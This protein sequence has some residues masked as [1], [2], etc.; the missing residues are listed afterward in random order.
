MTRRPWIDKQ[1]T[2]DGDEGVFHIS[3]DEHLSLF[4]TRV[5]V[6]KVHRLIESDN[7]DLTTR[8]KSKAR[9]ARLVG[10]LHFSA[11]QCLLNGSNT[12]LQGSTAHGTKAHVNQ[13]HMRQWSWSADS[14]LALP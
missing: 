12:S 5:K 9:H 14:R 10:S 4:Q 6:V 1:T 13:K 11:I 7:A 3:H 2:T 8:R